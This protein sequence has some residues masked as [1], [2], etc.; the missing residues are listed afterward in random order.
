MQARIHSIESFGTVD[1]PGI[2][3]VIFFK[4][5]SLRCQYCHN[6]DTW[7]KDN[8]T[9]YSIEELLSEILKY[10]SYFGKTGGVTASGGEPLLQ[11]EFVTELFK[12]LKDRG[13][14]TAC[15][16][17]GITFNPN[18]TEN[19]LAHQR[20]MEV[21]DLFL[22]DLKQ[23]DPKKHKKLTGKDNSNILAFA[24]YLSEHNKK[25][26]IRHVLIPEITS[27]VEDLE[28]LKEFISTLD[29]VEKI[30]VLPYHTMGIIKYQNLGIPYPL[31]NV[32]PPTKKEIEQAKR[33]LGI[34]KKK[35]GKI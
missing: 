19:V 6:P 2:R 4:G 30:E 12:Q 29:T 17:S 8:G 25:I 23:A 22:L 15:D 28:K 31:E 26:W 34:E 21:T 13:I 16:T 33:I 27:K 14:H 10:R 20:L 9:I 18:Q 11:I 32:L 24:R 35:R 3:F 5:C 7:T 1:G